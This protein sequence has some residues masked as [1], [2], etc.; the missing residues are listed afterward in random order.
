MQTGISH[1]SHYPADLYA[2]A[3]IRLFEY[4]HH[5]CDE[6]PYLDAESHTDL[7]VFSHGDEYTDYYLDSYPY[8]DDDVN[9]YLDPYIDSDGY[10]N[11]CPTGGH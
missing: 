4:I 1:P 7:P 8:V 9:F 3:D 10:P 5:Y 6:D 2:D 11:G